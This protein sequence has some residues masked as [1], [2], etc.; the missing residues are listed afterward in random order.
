[1]ALYPNLITTAL[2]QVIYPGTKK[3]LV[4]SGMVEDDIRIEGS[5]VT[6]SLIFD[7]ET[8]PFMK[9]VLKAAE[10]NLIHFCNQ[11]G[12]E[13]VPEIKVKLRQAPRPEPDKL[14]QK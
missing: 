5:K 7:K 2:T 4:E 11:A 1:M 8:D 12:E 9:S 3:N 13:I 10:A 14:L 6:F